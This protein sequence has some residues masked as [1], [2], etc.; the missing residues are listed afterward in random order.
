[1]P[2]FWT[3]A[4]LIL[5]LLEAA[6][7][8]AAC[9]AHLHPPNPPVEVPARPQPR[10]AASCRLSWY[11]QTMWLTHLPVLLGGCTSSAS[12]ACE[13]GFN[14][15]TVTNSS[16][17]SSLCGSGKSTSVGGSSTD[18]AFDA[19]DNSVSTVGSTVNGSVAS[20]TG[21]VDGALSD[22]T[23]TVDNTVSRVTGVLGRVVRRAL[24]F[25]R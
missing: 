22:V 10:L 7:V 12:A 6:P 19:I 8:K 11:F 14:N 17:S 9:S 16:T 13:V 20:V 4:H 23:G 2:T 15:N 3:Q 5:D 24:T 21:T 25:G 18:G 1:V